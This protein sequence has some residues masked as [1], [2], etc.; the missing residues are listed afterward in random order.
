MDVGTDNHKKQKARNQ[1]QGTVEKSLGDSAAVTFLPKKRRTEGT[2]TPVPDDALPVLAI[3]SSWF[4]PRGRLLLV[5]PEGAE[6]DDVLEV[7]QN[8]DKSWGGSLKK[9][10]ENA[11]VYM[12]AKD[13]AITF[14]QKKEKEWRY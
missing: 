7:S 10:R 12:L 13:A 8:K 4:S 9:R 2:E 1:K 14:L 3:G 5:F 6:T 11:I